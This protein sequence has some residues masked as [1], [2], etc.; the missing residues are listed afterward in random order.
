MGIYSSL[1]SRAQS[2]NKTETNAPVSE[3]LITPA[4]VMTA[5]RPV[6]AAKA[7][8]MLVRGERYVTPWVIATG[9]S[10]AEGNIARLIDK[11]FPEWGRGVT[12]GGAQADPIADTAAVLEIAGAA[13]FAPRVSKLAK[14]A[15][16]ITFGAE[17]VKTGW[18]LNAAR[19]YKQA[20]VSNE[21]PGGQL[22]N[23]PVDPIG[24]ES[25]L[26]KLE[27]VVFAAAT[28]DFEPGPFRTG[29]GLTALGHSVAGAYHGEKARAGYVEQLGDM[30]A[31]LNAPAA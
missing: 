4:N 17:A 9:L 5:A 16:L 29:L 15:L 1:V 14:T 24:K 3:K 26:E 22:L 18:S 27:T 2:A 28:N 6:L 10:D 30:M 31:A 7:A 19:I 13:M 21:H 25:M 11:L 23:I 20:T 8:H 12:R